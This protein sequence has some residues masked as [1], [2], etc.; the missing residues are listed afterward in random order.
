MLTLL[1]TNHEG[2]TLVSVTTR[3]F[4]LVTVGAGWDALEFSLGQK[5]RGGVCAWAKRPRGGAIGWVWIRLLPPP[6]L[7][8]SSPISK[9]TLRFRKVP[10]FF[11]PLLSLSNFGAN[12]SERLSI[13]VV[14]LESL[15]N[16]SSVSSPSLSLV[17]ICVRGWKNLVLA[18][19]SCIWWH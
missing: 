11:P 1:L 3:A 17:L 8:L 18:F 19:E 12:P 7:S 5:F 2:R 6:C 4:V 9:K 10:M 16:T 13:L 15:K 14:D